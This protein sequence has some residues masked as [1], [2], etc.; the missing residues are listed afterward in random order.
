MAEQNDAVTM[1]ISD[2][3]W[4]LG[5]RVGGGELWEPVVTSVNEVELP[6]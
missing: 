6:Y 4:R 3:Q 2:V 1:D 5:Q